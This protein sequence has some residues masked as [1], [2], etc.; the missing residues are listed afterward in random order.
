MKRRIQTIVVKE[1]TVD[2]AIDMIKT[3]KKSYELY[4]DVKIG[5]DVIELAVKLSKRYIN[6]KYLPDKAIDLIDEAAAKLKLTRTEDYYKVDEIIKGIT[7]A[8]F[9]LNSELTE[10]NMKNVSNITDKIDELDEIMSTISEDRLKKYNEQ[11]ILGTKYIE[12]VIST[13]TGIPLERLTKTQ[14][15]KLLNMQDNLSKY[16]IG[17]QSAVSSITRAILRANT[18]LKDPG[19][20]GHTDGGQLTEK[21]KKRPY[22]VLLF[23]EIEKAHADI[24]DLLLQVLDEGHLT[25]SHGKKIDFKNT[26]IIMTSNIGASKIKS[27]KN[28]GF[29]EKDDDELSEKEKELFLSELKKYFKPEF[30]NRVD[31]IVVFESLTKEDIDKIVMLMIDDLN[32]R[33]SMRNIRLTL[34][35]SAVSLIAQN[36][37]SKEYGA[38]QLSRSIQ[39]MIEDELSKMILKKQIK[40]ND[41]I[42]VS[43]KDEKLSFSVK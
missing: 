11:R 3:L 1:P 17:Q 6:D 25:D 31:E 42:K 15:D 41:E 19:Y 28:L 43:V 40:D 27:Q 33:L 34:D 14:E 12:Q 21:I 36:G 30:I 29:V 38:R 32:E 39:K 20:V 8:R 23:D 16:V 13:I 26:I 2:E 4:H 37:Y 24:F 10:S 9:S 35:D 18:G 5:D 22:C 7:D